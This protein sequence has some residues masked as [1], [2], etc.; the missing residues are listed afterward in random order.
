M[1]DRILA[2]ISLACLIAF[3]STVPLFVPEIDLIIVSTGC[4][5]LAAFDFWRELFKPKNGD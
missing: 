3:V 1:T 5:V 4:V 2:L